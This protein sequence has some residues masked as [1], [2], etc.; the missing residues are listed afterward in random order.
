MPSGARIV[1]EV[2]AAVIVGTGPKYSDINNPHP[3]VMVGQLGEVG[4]VEMS[5]VIV[6]TKGTAPG[7]VLIQYNLHSPATPDATSDNRPPS[8]LWDV[9]TRVGGFAGSGLQVANCPITPFVINHVDSRCIGA[10]TSMHITSG[11]GNLYIENSWLWVADHDIED[12]NMT[13]ITVYA[14]RGLLIEGSRIWLVGTAVEH[15]AL[16][17]YQLVNASD[18]WM[19]QIQTETPYYQPNPPA[20]YPFRER[21]AEYWDP[22]FGAQCLHN[23]Y[24]REYHNGT[25]TLDLPGSP[26]CAMAW[27][28]RI[29]SSENVVIFG[30]GLYSFFANF[31]TS[32]SQAASGENCQARI[33]AIGPAVDDGFPRGALMSK[34]L[35]TVQIYNLNT[36]GAVSMVTQQGAD[37]ALWGDNY[38]NFA[39]TLAV[40]RYRRPS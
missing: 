39:S 5:D 23:P 19:G 26:P 10:H 27:G 12:I 15:H 4:Y 30:A 28:L 34:D 31:H 38:A 37:M 13:R 21:S 33:F 3:V 25:A 22:D 29:L 1:G 6:S 20:P 16:Y 17:Q 24:N 40:F 2:L 32:C 8:G 9:H 36:V 7:A 14:G 35:S 18:I 11:A